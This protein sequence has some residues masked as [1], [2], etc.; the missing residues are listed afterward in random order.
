MSL[1]FF[2]DVGV[3]GSCGDLCGILA[4]DTNSQV[5]GTVCDLLCSIVGVKEF[6][7]LI[8]K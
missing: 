2:A 8:D 4:Q 6:I 5:V 7:Q 1:L 3:V